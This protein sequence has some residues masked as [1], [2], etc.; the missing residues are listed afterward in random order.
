MESEKSRSTTASC[1][2]VCV[3]QTTISVP[4]VPPLRSRSL[5]PSG[6]LSLFRCQYY[7]HLMYHQ[8]FLLFHAHSDI[9][10][11][12][13][14]LFIYFL[15]LCLNAL[16]LSFK[17]CLEKSSPSLVLVLSLS[18]LKKISLMLSLPFFLSPPSRC[19]TLL[20]STLSLLSIWPF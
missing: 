17:R 10:L 8:P 7:S 2:A 19:H 14:A 12:F 18:L 1:W 11:C 3:T 20:F 4:N 9:L 16:H 13:S 5:S 6:F 15:I